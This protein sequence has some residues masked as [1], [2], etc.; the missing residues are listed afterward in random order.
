[1]GEQAIDQLEQLIDD[2]ARL[3]PHDLPDALLLESHGRLLH[4]ERRLAGI[5]ARRLQVIDN[6]D[7]TTDHCARSTKAWLVEEQ[8]LSRSDAATRLQLARSVVARPAITE[9]MLA[10]EISAEQGRVIVS[11]LPKL[12]TPEA[13]DQGEKLLLDHAKEADPTSMTATRQPQ[14]DDGT[15]RDPKN[16]GNVPAIAT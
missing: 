9:A 7:V 15:G 5:C 12:T 6:R 10:G 16:L 2:L 11:F 1:M 14:Q 4:L 13:R 8:R 3:D